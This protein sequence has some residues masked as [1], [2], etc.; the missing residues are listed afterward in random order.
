VDLSVLRFF[1]ENGWDTQILQLN[2][3]CEC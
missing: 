1:Q 2:N 3:N